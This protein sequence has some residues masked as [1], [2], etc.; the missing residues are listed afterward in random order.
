MSARGLSNDS[1][2]SSLRILWARLLVLLNRHS[3]SYM[4][5]ISMRPDNNPKSVYGIKKPP[6][7][8]VPPAAKIYLAEG[9][10]DGAQKY[11]PY[12]WRTNSVA[13]SVYVGAFQRHVDQWWDGEELADDS[14]VHHLAHA[15]S[16]L[17]IIVD[18]KETGNLVDDRPLPGAATDLIKRLTED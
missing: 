9:F 4:G 8:L 10:K 17:A 2:T 14:N 6:M 13:A 12:N 7:E 3:P 18:A 1:S 15:L 11:G 5:Y 16:C